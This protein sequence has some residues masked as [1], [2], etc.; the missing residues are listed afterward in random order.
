MVPTD[1]VQVL[2]LNASSRPHVAE[3]SHVELRRLL[4][5]SNA[6]IVAID[7][8]VI[9]YALAFARD[10]PYDGEEF[11]ALRSLIPEPFLYIDQVATLGSMRRTGIGRRIYGSLERTARVRGSRRLCCEVNT[12]PP[13]PDSLAFHSRLGFSRLGSF[14]TGDGRRVDLLQKCLSVEA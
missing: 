14:A 10:D 1:E 2:T 4:S 9:G 5:L 11:I 12:A 8:K 13:N 6:H 7:E 3:L